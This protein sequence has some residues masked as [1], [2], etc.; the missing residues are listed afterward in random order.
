MEH[1][2]E[3]AFTLALFIAAG[4]FVYDGATYAVLGDRAASDAFRVLA[5]TPGGMHVQGWVMLTV[6]IFLA[7]GWADRD[8]LLRVAVAALFG[9]SAFVV[10]TIAA[11]WIGDGHVSSIG[12]LSKWVAL[13]A[14]ARLI[15]LLRPPYRHRRTDR[16]RTR[17]R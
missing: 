16:P 3:K 14:V 9:Y 7:I 1:A 2:K 8:G 15:W 12:A 17:T 10:Y 6:A 5:Y 13:L 11:T 4:Q